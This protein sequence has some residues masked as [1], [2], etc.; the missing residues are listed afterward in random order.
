MAGHFNY[1]SSYKI[2]LED[3]IGQLP[4][5]VLLLGDFS[6]HSQA[7]GLQQMQLSREDG[8]GLPLQI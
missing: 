1:M 3:L 8:G 4:P 6:A 2:E 5:P 7:M